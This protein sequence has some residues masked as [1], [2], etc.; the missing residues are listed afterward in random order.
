M[1]A[2][3]LWLLFGLAL[4]EVAVRQIAKENTHGAY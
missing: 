1:T 2:I 4:V 3:R